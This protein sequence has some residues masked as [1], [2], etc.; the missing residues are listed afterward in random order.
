MQ[1]V[2]GIE[3]MTEGKKKWKLTYKS[4]LEGNSVINP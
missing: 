1:I 2:Q 4:Q 3:F